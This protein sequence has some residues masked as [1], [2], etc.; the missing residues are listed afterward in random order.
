MEF[1]STDLSSAFWE[2]A[3]ERQA[4]DPS[5]LPGRWVAERTGAGIVVLG[6]LALQGDSLRVSAQIQKH[7]GASN[8]AILDPVVVPAGE[9][10]V[11]AGIEKMTDRVAA[12]LSW[13]REVGWTDSTT[14]H[15]PPSLAVKEAFDAGWEAWGRM[16]LEGARLAFERTLELDS[17]YTKAKVFLAAAHLD[18][19]NLREADSLLDETR[20]LK[21]DWGPLERLSWEMARANLDGDR[22][23][24]YLVSKDASQ[25]GLS[26]LWSLQFSWHALAMN[27]PREALDAIIDLDP[28]SYDLTIAGHWRFLGDRIARALHMLGDHERELEEVLRFREM[29]PDNEVFLYHEI[30]ARAALGQIAELEGLVE[31]ASQNLPSPV[32]AF[33]IAA[34]ELK[35]HRYEEASRS[36]FERQLTARREAA[37]NESGT[38]GHQRGIAWNLVH[39]GRLEEAQLIVDQLLL[40]E[41]SDPGNL[42]L[43]G[44]LAA[45]RGLRDEALNIDA[46]LAALGPDWTY[47]RACIAAQ[48]QDLDQAMDL[49]EQA[50]EE[51]YR[52]PI[53]L[54]ADPDLEPL[55]GFPRFQRFMA[56]RG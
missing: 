41:P 32:N 20:D 44:I 51:G 37:A 31:E 34:F 35:A 27:R 42:S 23:R 33:R 46:Q 22:E 28:T 29:A 7:G 12:A 47:S 38:P 1:V 25:R 43:F 6:S 48:L 36:F 19:G 11:G 9:A 2:T 30:R 40:R 24:Q 54:H 13:Y 5:F 15:P 17:S 49:L 21:D 4:R 10:E 55:W 52:Y 56:P 14:T 26:P 16:D 45:K 39:L 53:G 3:M 50:Y 18:L 8:V